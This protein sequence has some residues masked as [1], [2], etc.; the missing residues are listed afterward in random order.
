[1]RSRETV[2]AGVA[3]CILGLAGWQLMRG[4]S[5]AVGPVSQGSAAGVPAEGPAAVS[6]LATGAVTPVELVHMAATTPAGVRDVLRITRSATSSDRA[7]LR[8]AALHAFDPLV[9]GNAAKALG[10]LRE[11]SADA[12]LLALIEDP[13]PRVRQDAVKACGLDG[14]A[15][16]TPGL[17]R[18][19]A[20]GDPNLR[21]L[22]LEAL[23]KIGGPTAR[24]LV[25]RVAADRDATATDR[26]FASAALER[27]SNDRGRAEP[28]HVRAR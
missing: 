5:P 25:A 4:E 20:T 17:Q 12:D 19:L 3:A 18:A 2:L 13:R 15:A 7:A 10:R 8:D 16:A 11:F 23:G 1:M 26:V 27:I 21:P 22:V 28:P 9:A 24:A 14:G 6:P